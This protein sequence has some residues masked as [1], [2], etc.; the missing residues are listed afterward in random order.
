MAIDYLIEKL[1]LHK[2]ATMMLKSYSSS[3]R[4]LIF[5]Y[6]QLFRETVQNLLNA[7]YLNKA[8]RKDKGILR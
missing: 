6:Y 8:L 1:I 7:L 2:E 3:K 4:I 5:N